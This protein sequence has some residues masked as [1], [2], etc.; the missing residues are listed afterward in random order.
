MLQALHKGSPTRGC[1]KLGLLASRLA[2]KDLI[3]KKPEFWM[4]SAEVSK[5]Q[6]A[7]WKKRPVVGT[8]T[9]AS[10]EDDGNVTTPPLGCSA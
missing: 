7:L 2:P 3:R 9:N 4:S 5:T 1:P 8:A 6:Q 10:W